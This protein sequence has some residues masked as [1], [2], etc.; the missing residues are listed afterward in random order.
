MDLV[1]CDISLFLLSICLTGCWPCCGRC[2]CLLFTDIYF[3]LNEIKVIVIAFFVRFIWKLCVKPLKWS[4]GKNTWLIALNR[5][6]NLLNDIYFFALETIFCFLFYTSPSIYSSSSSSSSKVLLRIFWIEW[7]QFSQMLTSWM[8]MVSRSASLSV[9][10]HQLHFIAV[11]RRIKNISVNFN[12]C[13][14]NVN[15][16]EHFKWFDMNGML[17]VE[18]VWISH[19]Y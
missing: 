2:I 16:H 13:T 19:T 12:L 17:L 1:K 9:Y 7:K 14:R 5:I 11:Q 6:K 4:V 3:V 8:L 18:S 15:W 10:L